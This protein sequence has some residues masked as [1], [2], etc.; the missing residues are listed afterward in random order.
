MTRFT[1]VLLLTMAAILAAC[2][3]AEDRAREQ[4]RL[5]MIDHQHCLDL[6]FEPGTEPYGK[7]RLKL[8]EIRAANKQPQNNT[9]FGVGVGVGIGL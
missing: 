2:T 7:C 9:H 3:S 5:D 4:A 8:K 1:P 6:G